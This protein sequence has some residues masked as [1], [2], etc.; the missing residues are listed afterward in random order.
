MVSEK[1]GKNW[2]KGTPNNLV[3]QAVT[4]V[5]RKKCYIRDKLGRRLY[6]NSEEGSYWSLLDAFLEIF[7]PYQL[8]AMFEITSELLRKK[9]YKPTTKGEIVKWMGI[10]IV[11][12]KTRYRGCMRKLWD[13]VSEYTLLTAQDF[14]KQAWV[15]IA[16]KN[17]EFC[18]V[19]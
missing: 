16:W 17:V 15:T 7:P 9:R 18:L 4:R 3:G 12:K 2:V 11:M 8:K 5:P 10:I 19:E 14:K 1:H 13:N 6:S